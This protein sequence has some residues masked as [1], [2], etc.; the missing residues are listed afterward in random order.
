MKNFDF[1]PIIVLSNVI[2][3]LIAPGFKIS[4]LNCGA[5]EL[6]ISVVFFIIYGTTA[7]I[8]NQSLKEFKMAE[9]ISNS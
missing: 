4:F 1:T 6:I 2:S 5:K 3:I 9:K 8:T 7:F